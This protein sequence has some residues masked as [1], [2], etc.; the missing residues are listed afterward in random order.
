M[1]D[2]HSAIQQWIYSSAHASDAASCNNDSNKGM[3]CLSLARLEAVLSPS[4]AAADY[5]SPRDR[6]NPCTST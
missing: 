2:Y 3:G 6:G 4:I 1:V 5:A